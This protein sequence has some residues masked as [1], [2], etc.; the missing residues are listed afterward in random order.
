M[1][2]IAQQTF[3]KLAKVY[4]TDAMP[5]TLRKHSDSND[6]HKLRQEQL[7]RPH[8]LNDLD[9]SQHQKPNQSTQ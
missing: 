3:E 4:I 6:V 8:T 9:K 5:R 7:E 2:Q 1:A